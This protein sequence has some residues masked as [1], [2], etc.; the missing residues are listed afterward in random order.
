VLCVLVS[1]IA[2]KKGRS[3]VTLFLCMAAPAVP[4]MVAI[5]YALGGNM[6][7]KGPAMWTAA[8]LCPVAGFIW[9][10]MTPNK[11]Q[12]ATISGDYGDLKKCPFCAESVRK[13]AIKCKHCGSDLCAV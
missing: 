6:E 13:E 7:A 4:L 11:E 9:A 8:F 5:S 2:S 12:M 1:L 3:G 10:I